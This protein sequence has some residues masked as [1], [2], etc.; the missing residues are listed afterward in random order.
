[1][2]ANEIYKH[3]PSI[4]MGRPNTHA[5]ICNVAHGMFSWGEADIIEILKSDYINEYE[6]KVSVS[7]LKV[8]FKKKKQNKGHNYLFKNW[9][10]D[11]YRFSYIMPREMKTDAVLKMIG[12]H[13]I[14]IGRKIGIIF[15]WLENGIFKHEVMLVGDTNKYAS[16]LTLY[17]YRNICRLQCFKQLKRTSN[18][19]E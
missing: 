13:T 2:I 12:E 15:C 6:V 8:D 3:I 9:E 1:M 14:T 16:K 5:V 10:N 7:D 19:I 17:D 11:I 4:F 18:E